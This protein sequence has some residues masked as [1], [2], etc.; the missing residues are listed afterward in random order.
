M[1]VIYYFAASGEIWIMN[2]K[3]WV[4]FLLPKVLGWFFEVWVEA[5]S[6]PPSDHKN[7]L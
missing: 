3:Y 5:V 7:F 6:Y 1:V 2:S 4:V